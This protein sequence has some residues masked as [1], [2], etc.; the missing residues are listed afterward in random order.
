MLQANGCSPSQSAAV[1]MLPYTRALVLAWYRNHAPAPPRN[2]TCKCYAILCHRLHTWHLAVGD[3]RICTRPPVT[4]GPATYRSRCKCFLSSSGSQLDSV[5]K[6]AGTKAHGPSQQKP[7]VVGSLLPVL[8][9]SIS[10]PK[11]LRGP[12][13][14]SIAVEMGTLG[15]ALGS[16]AAGK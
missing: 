10:L 1:P 11:L 12:L 16:S 3:R 7:L 15:A 2:G 4:S 14:R 13:S 6:G 9:W 5:C 8:N